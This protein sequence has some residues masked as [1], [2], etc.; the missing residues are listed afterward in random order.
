MNDLP[1][2]DEIALRAFGKLADELTPE[3]LDEILASP[4]ARAICD[5]FTRRRAVE[6]FCRTCGYAKRF[7]K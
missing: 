3:E 1:T 7:S 4:R 6:H 5:G 2:I